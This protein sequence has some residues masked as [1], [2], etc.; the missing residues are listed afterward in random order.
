V[1]S[2][3]AG[4]L[5]QANAILATEIAELRQAINNLKASSATAN[6]MQSKHSLSDAQ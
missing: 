4:G 3:D 2:Q 1:A 6:L 5:N